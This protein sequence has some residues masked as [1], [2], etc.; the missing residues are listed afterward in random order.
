MIIGKNN[1]KEFY[2][3]GELDFDTMVK[4]TDHGDKVF[5]WASD[6]NNI[7]Y[8]PLAGESP[9]G[10]WMRAEEYRQ[11]M[12]EIA[13]DYLCTVI[14]VAIDM[15]NLDPNQYIRGVELMESQEELIW[16]KLVHKEYPLDPS[17][18]VALKDR[19]RHGYEPLI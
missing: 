8:A 4:P 18:K 1:I 2:N 12:K 3:P 10:V 17:L 9:D 13:K 11:K 5:I 19:V 14:N 7:K 6:V 16:K 15:Y